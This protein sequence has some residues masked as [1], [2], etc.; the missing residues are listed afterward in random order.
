MLREWYMHLNGQMPAYEWEFSD[1]NPPI[2]AWVAWRVYEYFHGD[3]GAGLEAS[4][5]TSW[6]GL[7]AK[8]LQQNASAPGGRE[9]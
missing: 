1:I 6:T 9:G 7:I 4:H 2:H 5:Q 8:I 3:T